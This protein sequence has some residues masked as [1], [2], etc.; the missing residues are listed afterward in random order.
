MK[1]IMYHYVRPYNPKLPDLK[2][3]HIDDFKLQLDYFESKYGFVSKE[4]F[5]TSLN[6]GKPAEGVIITFDDGLSCHYDYAYKE[7]KKRNLWGIFYVPTKVYTE[8]KMLDVHRIHLL[9]AVHNGETVYQH[10]MK[11]VTDDML[12]D[13]LVKEFRELTYKHQVNDNYTNLVKRILNYYISYDF[14][15]E[16][17]DS[18]MNILVQEELRKPETFYASPSQLKEMHDS[19]MII[20]SHTVNHPVLSKLTAD[21]QQAEI[22]NSFA[23]L[24]NICGEFNLKTFCYPYGGFHSFTQ[25]TEQI[26]DNEDCLFSFNVEHRDITQQDLTQRRQALPRYDCN[27]FPYGQCRTIN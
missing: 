19:G 16:I 6:T 7:L 18:L 13:M 23:V 12:P 14:R 25:E 2:H 20:G 27:Q 17:L 10:L 26:L 21:E 22:K 3:L 4:D 11:L 1:S 24:H 15:E 9:L 5:I 8:N